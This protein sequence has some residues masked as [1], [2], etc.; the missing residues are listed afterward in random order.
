MSALFTNNAST[1]IPIDLPAGQTTIILT[2][3]AGALFPS[4]SPP[5][6]FM[7]TIEDRRT[8]QIE[9]CRCTARNGDVLTVV[10]AQEGTTTQAFFLGA[11]VSNRLT[12]GTI[13]NFAGTPEAPEDGK[14]YGRQ[15]SAWVET[16]TKEDYDA[17]LAEQAVIDAGQDNSIYNNNIAITGLEGDITRI[18]G[19]NAE[20]GASIGAIET[21]I[22]NLEGEIVR[23][24]DYNAA[25][26]T[27]INAN[28]SKNTTQDTR[29]DAVESKNTAQDGRLDAV[30]AKNTSQDTAISSKIGEAPN[31]G[32]QYARQ[33]LAWAEVVGT[34]GGGSALVPTQDTP[35]ATPLDGQLWW[36]SD[37]G[38]MF[39][40]Y[41]DGTSAQWVQV[42]GGG[43]GSSGGGSALV[44]IQDAPP[45]A[46][47][48]GQ[49]WWESDTGDLYLWFD[50]GNTQQWVQVNGGGAYALAHTDDVPPVAPVDGQ[51]WWR[52]SNGHMYVYYDDGSSAQWVDTNV[53]I[54]PVKTAQVRNRIC[55][56][57]MQISQENGDT[58]S[59]ASA[60]AVYYV[61][62]QWYGNWSVTGAA[63]QVTRSSTTLSP[64]GNSLFSTGVT[65]AKASLAASEYFL[66]S[67]TIE[68][69]NVKD[70]KWGTTGALPVVLR[71]WVW[72][73]T[74]GLYSVRIA[75][76][77][78]SRSYVAP[79]TV[80]TGSAWQ[81]VVIPI[82]GDTT[83][84]W[85][86]D[87][88]VGIYIHFA[89]AVGTTF[90]GVAGWQAGNFY[91]VPGQVNGAAVA[92]N[93][94][95][96]ADVGLYLDPEGTGL[97]P[98]FETPDY[99]D[100]LAR[101]QRYFSYVMVSVQAPAIGDMIAPWYT[102]VP[103]RTT[104][105][106][107]VSAAG[108]ASGASMVGDLVETDRSG[109]SQLRTT[110][111]TGYVIG[112]QYKLSAR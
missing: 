108:S 104:P 9:I 47:D 12:A 40:W 8:S 29:L 51:L 102:A 100:E 83:G 62:D 111:A 88:S 101:C 42:T 49:L 99:A 46:P 105:T 30:E 65:T 34:G 17:Q 60:G 13:L 25:Q 11:T 44:P 71:F 53:P 76:N 95:N 55:N 66:V 19:V 4:P 32:K 90:V 41:D 23:I 92:S 38:Q 45:D 28:T 97:A 79:F 94:M 31:D 85:T 106:L 61:A 27:A 98:P 36:E 33:S 39:I 64:N 1:R 75:N 69:A 26:D 74:P 18:D 14:I 96:F 56:P 81:Q 10:R 58:G 109:R 112:R 91:A 35:P 3:G 82:P 89:R 52:S 5:D 84:T 68:G 80:T 110:V 103:M 67:T 54:T 6:Y 86:K 77:D 16:I 87:N 57:A 20:Q 107:S 22:T 2:S 43:G 72:A 93:A 21:D 7:V 15:D 50:D 63:L 73:Q 48:P 37:S 70:F 78:T 59:A 24:D